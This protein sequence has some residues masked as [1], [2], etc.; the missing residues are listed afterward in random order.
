MAL[1]TSGFLSAALRSTASGCWPAFRTLRCWAA[2]RGSCAPAG[3]D[4][5][6]ARKGRLSC[7]KTVHFFR[8]QPGSVDRIFVTSAALPPLPSSSSS[9]SS[10]S[11]S[12]SSSASSAS[13]AAAVSSAAA[14]SSS[15]YFALS[16]PQAFDNRIDVLFRPQLPGAA[17]AARKLHA[18]RLHCGRGR[19]GHDRPGRGRWRAPS[20]PADDAV[21][22]KDPQPATKSR[23]CSVRPPRPSPTYGG[24][25]RH[26]QHQRDDPTRS[27]PFACH[28]IARILRLIPLMAALW[29]LQVAAPAA[30]AFIAVGETVILLHRPLPLVGVS[31]WMERGCQ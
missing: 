19:R 20:R 7:S 2:M 16:R 31:I 12:S 4:G 11:S 28:L 15:Y 5:S 13:A 14:A 29:G 23:S 25:V 22:K 1:I 9:F 24:I 26:P 17:A 6:A 21:T 8:L 10:S 18:R 27:N 3:K 30:P